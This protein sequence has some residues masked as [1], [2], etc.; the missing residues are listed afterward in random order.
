MIYDD[1]EKECEKIREENEKY[2]NIFQTDLK[3]KG[4]SEKTIRAH[5]GNANFYINDFLLYGESI[6]MKDGCGKIDE[7][8]GEFFIRKCM[9]STPGTIKST[10][11]SLKKFYKCMLEHDEIEKDDYEYLCDLINDGIEDWQETCRIYNDPDEENPF[12]YF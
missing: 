7:F 3:E 2:L 1:Y 9:W 6:S 12:M 11:T 5:V 8:L 4:F 10:A